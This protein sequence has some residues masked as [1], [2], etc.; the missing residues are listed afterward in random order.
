MP[1]PAPPQY[2]LYNW[3]YHREANRF[4]MIRLMPQRNCSIIQLDD[5]C[6]PPGWASVAGQAQYGKWILRKRLLDI[7]P[8]PQQNPLTKGNTKP[9]HPSQCCEKLRQC[10][11]KRNFSSTGNTLSSYS[12]PGFSRPFN[13]EIY[14]CILYR[15]K[16]RRA[17]LRSKSKANVRATGARK[18]NSRLPGYRARQ[19][20]Q[21]P[22]WEWKRASS[23]P[24]RSQVQALRKPTR[25][26]L[27]I[28]T[29][30]RKF[31]LLN[32]SQKI[33]ENIKRI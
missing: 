29:Q 23:K 1:K 31:L 8:N 33:S 26:T 19:E 5:R 12:Q 14:Q 28:P 15:V 13:T 6:C 7:D 18:T 24:T 11:V 32:G 21:G 22:I 9:Y 30:S 10:P 16:S 27:S 17:C 3:R 25:E 2:P 4:E 20:T